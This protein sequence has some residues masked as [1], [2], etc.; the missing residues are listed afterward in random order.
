MWIGNGNGN[1][2]DEEGGESDRD[3]GDDYLENDDNDDDEDSNL[4]ESEY[5]GR[6]CNSRTWI[7]PII[8]VK[9]KGETKRF[10]ADEISSMFFLITSPW[11]KKVLK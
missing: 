1:D 9:H 6:N 2:N 5:K 4:E 11:F 7:I 10:K 8:E 3:E